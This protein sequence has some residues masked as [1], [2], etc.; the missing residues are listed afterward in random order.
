MLSRTLT[1]TAEA[2]AAF[3]G[4]LRFCPNNHSWKWGTII[5]DRKAREVTFV[6]THT[7]QA[8]ERVTIKDHVPGLTLDTIEWVVREFFLCDLRLAREAFN[9]PNVRVV[10]WKVNSQSLMRKNSNES[11][12]D[13][14]AHTNK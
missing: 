14:A 5:T 6:V 2:Q 9:A 8:V 7:N 12:R 3:N 10:E 13:L 4:M 11:L 1:T